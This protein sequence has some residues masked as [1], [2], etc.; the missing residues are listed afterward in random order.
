MVIMA[1]ETP[2]SPPG[3]WPAATDTDDDRL[4]VRRQSGTE[5]AENVGKGMSKGK[6]KDS[7]DALKRTPMLPPEILEQYAQLESHE[8]QIVP[9]PRLARRAITDMHILPEFCISPTQRHL[10][11]WCWS[12]HAGERH[13]RHPT[14]MLIIY[15]DVPPFPSTT[16]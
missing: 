16:T 15:Q 5:I 9:M 12:A 2:T 3:S 6:R 7:T 10:H 13:L 1:D 11:L 4:D 14:Y 8:N